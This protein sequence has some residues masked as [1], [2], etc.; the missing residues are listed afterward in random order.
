M[1]A[2]QNTIIGIVEYADAKQF[3]KIEVVTYITVSV[4]NLCLYRKQIT[5][6]AVD[7]IS[8]EADT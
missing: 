6:D 2:S 8:H 4:L 3:Y 7:Y 5:L 1:V